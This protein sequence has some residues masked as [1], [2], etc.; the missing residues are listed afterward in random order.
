MSAFRGKADMPFCTAYVRYRCK[1]EMLL[2]CKCPLMT[3]S[4]H[5]SG[6]IPA[7]PNSAN[8]FEQAGTIGLV[9]PFLSQALEP[10]VA[11]ACMNGIIYL[12]GL[13]VVIM[14]ILSFLG[15]H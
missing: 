4:E 3:Q 7:N 13:I 2:H 8:R 11:E 9:F 1:A 12:I 10:T 5:P 15:L 14:A 6:P